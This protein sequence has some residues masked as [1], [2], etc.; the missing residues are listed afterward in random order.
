MPTENTNDRAPS[1]TWPYPLIKH[2]SKLGVH[3]IQVDGVK[4]FTRQLVSDGAAFPIVKAVNDLSWLRDVKE[5]SPKTITVARII[6]D[7]EGCTGVEEPSSDLD[8][9]S[10]RLMRV[11]LD[12]ISAEPI[13]HEVVDYWEVAN[14][15][16]PPGTEGYRR[17]GLLM[18][19]CMERARPEEIRLALFSLNAGTPEWDEMEAMVSTDVFA[20]ARE[21]RHILA[22]HEGVFGTDQPIDHMYGKRIPGAPRVPGAGSLCFRYRHLY[23]LLRQRD[24]IVPL[25]VSEFYAGGGYKQHGITPLEV[26]ERMSWYDTKARKDYWVLAFCPFTLGPMAQW[27][28]TNYEFAYPALVDY[29]LSIK[30]ERNASPST[31]LAQSPCP[32]LPREQYERV[33]V[34][35]PPGIGSEWALAAA[36]ATWE[37]HRYTIGGSADDAGIG[38][39]DVRVVI[40]IN[41]TLWSSDLQHFYETY[42]PGVQYIPLEA[43]SPEQLKR[44][45][46]RLE[47]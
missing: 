7:F 36:E 6:S 43:D 11:I 21:G 20:Q 26:A 15:P 13:L 32:G 4:Q 12:K 9:M 45:L 46:P 10:R 22:L 33:Y 17:L 23:H 8:R 5:I 35:L 31:T 39:L 28:K 1:L 37:D 29:A 42:Y 25:V 2:G 44:R 3:A 16:D 30:D 40:A 24:E 14:E 38:D 19:K 41:P 34:L 47:L 27:K 18:Q